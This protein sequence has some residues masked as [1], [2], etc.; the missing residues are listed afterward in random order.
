MK[1][2]LDTNPR[3]IYDIGSSV[4]HWTDSAKTVW[5][6][7]KYVA[8]EAMSE[9]KFLY[10]ED[11]ID[12]NIG[13]LTD[14]DNKKIEFFQNTEHPAGNSYYRENPEFSPA[15]TRLFGDDKKIIKTGMTLDSVVKSRGFPLP[16]LIKMDV[17]GAEMDILKGATETLKNCTD[18]ILE[19]QHVQYNIGAPLKDIVI[20]F[21]ESLGFKLVT[22]YFATASEMD[23]DYH[24]RKI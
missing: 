24:F 14:A 2:T 9:V 16:D 8:F 15:A 18:L 22:A 11:G 12:Y 6:D 21:V 10:D 4:L 17:Q 13:V 7:S 1:N 5:P 3:I 19:L 20:K 23:G